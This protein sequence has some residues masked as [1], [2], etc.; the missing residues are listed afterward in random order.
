MERDIKHK[1]YIVAV[2]VVEHI[3]PLTEVIEVVK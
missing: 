3:I 2:V 1:T